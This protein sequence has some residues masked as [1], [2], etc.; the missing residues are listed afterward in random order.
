[1]TKAK[2]SSPSKLR[3]SAPPPEG[4]FPKIKGF[5]ALL[6]DKW[7]KED[8]YSVFSSAIAMGAESLTNNAEKFASEDEADY[9]L[10]SV[11]A[12]RRMGILPIGFKSNSQFEAVSAGR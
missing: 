5:A 2:R 7:P 3:L 9:L 8:P 4:K 6:D 10:M 12:A 11:A 1:M